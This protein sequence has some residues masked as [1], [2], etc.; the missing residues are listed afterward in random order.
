MSIP[1][2]VE[3]ERIDSLRPHSVDSNLP[4]L[5][6]KNRKPKRH[7]IPYFCLMFLFLSTLAAGCAVYGIYIMPAL[8]KNTLAVN[9]AVVLLVMSQCTLLAMQ[10]IAIDLA[11]IKKSR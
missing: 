3:I 4:T 6:P 11:H 9:L 2:K 10:L 8:G 1:P 7:Y 5:P